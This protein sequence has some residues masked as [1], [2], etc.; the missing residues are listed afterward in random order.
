MAENGILFIDGNNFYHNIK[1]IKVNPS[2]IDFLKLSQIISKHFDIKFKK[3]IYYNSIPDIRDGEKKY[4][5]HMKF[6]SRI[7][8]IPDFEVKTRKLPKQSTAEVLQEKEEKIR[9]LNLCDKCKIQVKN[10]CFDCIG[11]SKKKEKGIDVMIA[12]DMVENSIN[13]KCDYCVLLSGDADFI[14]AM[15]LIKEIGKKTSSTSLDKGYSSELRNTFPFFV[16]KRDI[17]AQ[18]LQ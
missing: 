4:Y 18:A 12:V 9:M 1:K 6:L 7:A 11:E 15:N 10:H 17:I 2:E 8:K 16:L 3:I 13:N 14:P 5:G